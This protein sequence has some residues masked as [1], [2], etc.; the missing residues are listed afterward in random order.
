MEITH[1]IKRDFTTKLF[2]LQKITDAIL[3]A[4]TAANHGGL[5]D[6]KRISEMVY[7]ALLER[8]SMDG[9]YIPTVEEVQ[10]FVETKL[11]ES[12]F[13]DVAKGYILYRNQQTQKTKAKHIR[14]TN[15]FKAIRISS[16]L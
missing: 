15:K 13:F 14:E 10:D 11:M 9:K 1:I 4:M 2:H 16:A 3:K 7:E 5:E 12:G 6:A 8:K